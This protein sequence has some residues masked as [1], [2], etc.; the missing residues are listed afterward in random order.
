MDKQAP[1]P[2]EAAYGPRLFSPVAYLPLNVP[3]KGRTL[4]NMTVVQSI[5]M[6]APDKPDLG[7]VIEFSGDDWLHVAEPLDAIAD[8]IV[9]A[10]RS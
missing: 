2:K 6:L 7:S 4:V 8:A 10:V 9:K 3:G 1:W 5:R